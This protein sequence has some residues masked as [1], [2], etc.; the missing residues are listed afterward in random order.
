ME[1]AKG[2]A[3]EPDGS[4]DTGGGMARIAAVE[5]QV[6]VGV[7]ER[8][9][10]ALRVRRVSREEELEV[11]VTLRSEKADV[12]RVPVNRQVQAE[13]G[14][15]QEGDTLI[16]PV[17]EYVP[18]TEMRLVLKEEIHV[19][20]HTIE[21]AAVQTVQVRKDEVIVERR[22]G[23]AGEWVVQDDGATDR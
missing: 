19:R 2:P 20:K 11:P 14:P 23:Q 7:E 10:G 9:T 3:P 17:F 15:R 21:E 22:E 1:P 13:F 4:L 12:R 8:E 18:V 16:I 6:A 5:E